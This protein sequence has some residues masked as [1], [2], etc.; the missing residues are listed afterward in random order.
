[1]EKQPVGQLLLRAAGSGR[2]ETLIAIMVIA[3]SLPAPP[4]TLPNI[5]L[6]V[7]ILLIIPLL[8][9]RGYWA[10]APL[11]IVAGLLITGVSDHLLLCGPI[12][13]LAV[14]YAIAANRRIPAAVI[15]G[16][17]LI[18]AYVISWSQ[19]ISIAAISSISFELALLGIAAGVGYLRLQLSQQGQ[20]RGPA[21]LRLERELRTDRTS[22]LHENMKDS[23]NYMIMKADSIESEVKDSATKAQMGMIAKTG[24]T[25]LRDL[26]HYVESFDQDTSAGTRRPSPVGE[27]ITVIADALTDAQYLVSCS[28]IDPTRRFDQRIETAFALDFN[29]VITNIIRHSPERSTIAIVVAEDETWLSVSVTNSR[30]VVNSGVRNVVENFNS[31]MKDVGGR[32]KSSATNSTWNVTL[33]LPKH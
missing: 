19:S 20:N 27:T 1:M 29:E 5:A 3:I 24:R 17:W 7:L 30:N 9:I 12:A 21:Q 18:I 15:G 26:Q 8:N 14:E 10:I 11:F 25:A 4:A 16:Q 2:A 28:G 13:Y 6:E 23:L 33:L 32:M 31:R 22:Y